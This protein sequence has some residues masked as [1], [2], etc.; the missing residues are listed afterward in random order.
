VTGT[1]AKSTATSVQVVYVTADGATLDEDDT[2][3]NLA[4]AIGATATCSGGGSSCYGSSTVANASVTASIT[5]LNTVTLTGVGSGSSGDFTLSEV[6]TGITVSG[7]SN[8][9]SGQDF[10]FLSVLTGDGG[11]AVCPTG[12]TNGGG[13]MMNFDVTLGLTLSSAIAPLAG[14][15]VNAAYDDDVDGFVSGQ[16]IVDNSVVS[17]VLGGA[18]E[19]YFLS[20]DSTGGACNTSGSDICATQASQSA[21]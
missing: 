21:P 13:C 20:L 1:P 10:I 2:A 3:Q 9:E 14:L 17:G 11:P 4:A 12:V 16:I 8:G 19:I 6:G 5:V 7:G 15:T 18:S